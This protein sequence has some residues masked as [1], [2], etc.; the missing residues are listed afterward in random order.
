MLLFTMQ[1]LLRT[2]MLIYLVS[3]L[4]LTRKKVEI[5]EKEEAAEAASEEVAVAIEVA[6]EVATEV[7]SE[8]ATEVAAVAEARDSTITKMPSQLYE[9]LEVVQ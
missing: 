2:S 7:A 3:K 4:V 8:E 6:S 5:E 9:Q 1:V